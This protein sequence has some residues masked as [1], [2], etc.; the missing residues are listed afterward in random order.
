MKFAKILLTVLTLTVATAVL[1][2]SKTVQL[3]VAN[4]IQTCLL[5]LVPSLMTFMTVANFVSDSSCAE[6]LSTTFGKIVRFVFNLPE[7]CAKVVLLSVLGGYPCGAKLIGDMLGKNEIDTPTA[8]RLLRF[9]INASPAYVISA[10]G[11]GIFDSAKIGAIIFFS[12]VTTAWLVG[13]MFR[14][15]RPPSYTAT[16]PSPLKPSECFV[17]SVLDSTTS[18]ISIS[19]FVITF[20]TILALLNDIGITQIFVILTKPFTGNAETSKTL[21]YALFD[22]VTGTQN[23]TN[24]PP[25]HSLL[26][27]SAAVSFGG[28]SVL[29]QTAFCLSGHKINFFEVFLFRLLHSVL[30]AVTTYIIIGI[31]NETVTTAYLF[32]TNPQQIQTGLTSTVLFFVCCVFF[33]ITVDKNISLLLQR[34]KR[35]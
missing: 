19:G 8:Q 12:H 18:M 28:M 13:A 25:M 5:T 29:F 15:K 10:I 6:V 26:L 31:S 22:V 20:S 33:V 23:A 7:N 3:A 4:A 32:G 16:T 34:R 24:C 14:G 1:V 9:C 35:Q 30:T 11:I 2:L 17:K 21:L 27:C